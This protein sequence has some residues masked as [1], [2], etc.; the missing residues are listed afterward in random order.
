MV[1]GRMEFLPFLSVINNIHNFPFQTMH[2][3][4]L[5]AICTFVHSRSIQKQQNIYLSIYYYLA[6][7]KCA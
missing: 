7:Y 2:S 4:I 5:L 1:W 3:K 6:Y